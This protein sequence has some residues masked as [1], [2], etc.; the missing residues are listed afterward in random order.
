MNNQ[1]VHMAHHLYAKCTFLSIL[2]MHLIMYE[3]RRHK[4]G[5]L[6]E[7][8][9]GT[10]DLVQ[11]RLLLKTRQKWLPCMHDFSK[12]FLFIL[13]GMFYFMTK[14]VAILELFK[15][16]IVCLFISAWQ[17]DSFCQEALVAFIIN[18]SFSFDQ[19]YQKK[20]NILSRMC[21]ITIFFHMPVDLKKNGVQFN[22][23]LL[24][25]WT[26]TSCCRKLLFH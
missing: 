5:G 22:C 24:H 19:I 15:E 26:A 8:N 11:F 10:W 6:L 25:K 18:I 9:L 4:K 7:L 17:F 2:Y 16:T 12:F 23:M 1:A 13:I 14:C 21:D 20:F 3:T